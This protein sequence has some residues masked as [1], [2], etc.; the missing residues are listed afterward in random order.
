M[1]VITRVCTYP[2][3]SLGGVVEGFCCFFFA[4][5]SAPD[6]QNADRFR[7]V[8]RA[9]AR[10]DSPQTALGQPPSTFPR[11]R[12]RLLPACC[13]GRSLPRPISLKATH[14]GDDR[15]FLTSVPS[16]RKARERKAARP[17]AAPKATAA[18]GMATR[19]RGNPPASQV[20]S[21]VA[22]VSPASSSAYADRQVVDAGSASRHA[23]LGRSHARAAA[24]AAHAAASSTFPQGAAS[25]LPL[26][27]SI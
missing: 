5:D 12:T 19:T 17:K 22:A 3:K 8:C 11:T 18:A 23:C 27:A 24:V 9:T 1:G 2:L 14:S 7:L 6:R 13:H 16:S 15:A 4:P 10:P 21:T 25:E 20:A 26:S